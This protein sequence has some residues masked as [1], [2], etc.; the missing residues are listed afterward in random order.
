[1]YYNP[2]SQAI[3]TTTTII[4]TKNKEAAGSLKAVFFAGLLISAE[5]KQSNQSLYGEVAVLHGL[6][7]K[8]ARG[9]KFGPRQNPFIFKSQSRG[10]MAR[11]V[12]VLP[13]A[14][15]S[16]TR[17]KRILV[18]DCASARAVHWTRF[19]FRDVSLRK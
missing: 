19:H 13:S 11:A 4:L 16:M 7:P 8:T 18:S 17:D 3:R 12:R 5:H 15:A 2:A 1:M 10:M 9:T 6:L 14:H